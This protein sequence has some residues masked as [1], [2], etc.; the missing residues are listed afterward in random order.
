M[1]LPIAIVSNPHLTIKDLYHN[2]YPGSLI[3]T[4]PDH[5]NFNDLLSLAR[6]RDLWRAFVRNLPTHGSLAPHGGNE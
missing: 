2:N 1:K 4:T 3:S 5:N 6:D